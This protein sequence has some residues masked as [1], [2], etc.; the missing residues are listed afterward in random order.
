MRVCHYVAIT[1]YPPFGETLCWVSALFARLL[2]AFRFQISSRTERY[3]KSS[4]I[5]IHAHFTSIV[6]LFFSHFD[7]SFR[8]LDAFPRLLFPF[9]VTYFPPPECCMVAQSVTW[10]EVGGTW[11]VYVDGK[12][13]VLTNR[14]LGVSRLVQLSMEC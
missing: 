3:R 4:S 10:T 14:I 7:F 2:Q 9:V 8:F 11:S 6:A 5:I 12:T 13:N 1:F